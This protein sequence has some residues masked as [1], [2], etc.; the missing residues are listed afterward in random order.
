MKSN[1]WSQT[2]ALHAK[3]PQLE[4]PSDPSSDPGVRLREHALTLD[5]FVGALQ[6]R[7]HAERWACQTL[8]SQ[9]CAEKIHAELCLAAIE[10]A[11]LAAYLMSWRIVVRIVR[12]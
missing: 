2:G 1:R 9:P 4:I 10:A 7:V 3:A 8:A 6:P 12:S 5:E 11:D